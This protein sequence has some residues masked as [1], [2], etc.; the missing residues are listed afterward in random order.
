M[1][2]HPTEFPQHRRGDPLRQAEARVF[3]AMQGF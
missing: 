3:A 2:M 1:Q